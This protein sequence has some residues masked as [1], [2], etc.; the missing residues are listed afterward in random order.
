MPIA[1]AVLRLT[2]SSNLVGCSTGRSA[3]MFP[4]QSDPRIRRRVGSLP[5][6]ARDLIRR[7]VAVIAATSTPANRIAKA[8]TTFA[9]LDPQHRVAGRG[10]VE[11]SSSQ[12]ESLTLP[13]A[14]LVRNMLI[15][16]TAI[17]TAKPKIT[18]HI[19]QS[20]W[21]FSRHASQSRMKPTMTSLVS[22]T[23]M[24]ADEPRARS[25]SSAS[26]P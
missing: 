2:I 21:R 20:I 3:Q 14:P 7:G 18:A 13:R 12:R 4:S 11:V 25:D 16:M 22:P 10:R 8:A 1:L 17:P 15:P 26:T 19:V 23:F 5:E 24:R 9:C 6:L